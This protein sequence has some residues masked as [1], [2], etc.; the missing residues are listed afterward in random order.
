[1]RHQAMAILFVLAL[2]LGSVYLGYAVLDSPD[3][4]L[5]VVAGV[6]S[7]LACIWI[8]LRERA[9]QRFLLRVFIAALALRWIVGFAIYY[10]HQQAF[11][12]ADASTYDIFGHALSQVW[13]GLVDPRVVRSRISISRPGWGMYYYVASVYYLLGRNPLAIQFINATLGAAVCVIGYK[14]TQMI[15]PRQR[16]ARTVAILTAFSPSLIL[17]SSQG[18]KD[19]LIVLC[20]CLCTLYTLKLRDEVTVKN[21]ALLLISLVC[22]YSLRHYAAY[23][24]FVAIAGALLFAA[25]R[26]TPVRILQG[27]LVVIAI[28]LALASLDS[29]EVAQR[30]LDL[31]RI[32]SER[33]WG[34]KA[35]SSGYGGDVDITDPRAALTFLP[36]GTLYVLFAPFPWMISNLRQLI[37]LPE[38]IVW[39]ALVPMLVKG[40]WFAIRHR[41]RESFVICVFTLGLTLTYALYQTNVGTAYRHRAQLYVFFFVFISMGLEL[42]RA[43]RMKRQAQAALQ[44]P[45]L[46]GLA[47][48]TVPRPLAGNSIKA[49]S[50]R[51]K[52]IEQL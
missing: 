29:G 4:A 52:A 24:I 46:A 44:R 27:G 13:E 26:F 34:A 5:A 38:L 41:L 18:L 8:I 51:V 12:G 23:L 14:I 36:V 7:A 39:W 16:V 22:L 25:K 9:D 28:G 11:F 45:G 40:Y 30:A 21:F 6:V 19:A 43:E 1:M 2:S 50:M 20:L 37:T 3:A 32:Q 31:K 49:H 15:Y 48:V 33:V 42:R 35:A 10:K 17:W 47:P